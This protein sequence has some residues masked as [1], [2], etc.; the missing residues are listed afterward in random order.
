VQV[1]YLPGHG[2]RVE[3][4]LGQG[5]IDR[6]FKPVGR[7]TRGEFRELPFTEQVELVKSDLETSFW[8]ETSLVV[9]NSFGGYLFLH[10]QSHMQPYVGRVLLLSPILGDFFDGAGKGFSPPHPYRLRDL[11]ASGQMT[12]P[13]N[14]E[15]H[16]GSEDWQ[17]SPDAVTEFG[18]RLNISV[19][20]A[21]GLGHML[22]K[23]YV[24]G[25]LD[26]WLDH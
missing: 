14:C 16:V 18:S 11:V 17:S 3:T 23:D 2:G 7:E 21:P 4:G 8:A 19:T 15:I 20:V 24:G 5:L 25:V 22:G 6:G 10:A 9:A 26:R 13:K 1:Y 12:A